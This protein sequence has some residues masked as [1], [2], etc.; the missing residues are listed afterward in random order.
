MYGTYN[1]SLHI[2]KKLNKKNKRYLNPLLFKSSPKVTNRDKEREQIKKTKEK[3]QIKK[4]RVKIM[5]T[6]KEQGIEKKVCWLCTVLYLARFGFQSPLPTL[7]ARYRTSII[8]QLKL[9][10]SQPT[11]R[12]VI[13]SIGSDIQFTRESRVFDTIFATNRCGSDL[14]FSSLRMGSIGYSWIFFQTYGSG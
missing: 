8:I 5:V 1:I 13:R 3:K 10:N 2:Y 9:G 11:G 12:S 7:F 14:P 6:F 4:N